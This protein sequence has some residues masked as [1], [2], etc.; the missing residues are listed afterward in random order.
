MRQAV[1]AFAMGVAIVAS[2]GSWS[3]ARQGIIGMTFSM[4]QGPA[5]VDGNCWRQEETSAQ[6]TV[7]CDVASNTN[8]E[9]LFEP[10]RQGDRILC[11][12]CTIT[13]VANWNEPADSID[14]CVTIRDENGAGADEEVTS[15]CQTVSSFDSG[16]VRQEMNYVRVCYD[17]ISPQ[18]A[19]IGFYHDNTV[20]PGTGLDLEAECTVGVARSY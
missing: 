2:L 15:S 4:N 9:L 6:T 19:A 20:D 10:L 1:V 8:W 14:L 7:V 18:D 3:G 16:A 11:A 17:L 5:A 12:D 13:N